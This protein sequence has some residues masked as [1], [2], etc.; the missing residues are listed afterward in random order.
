MGITLD[1]SHWDP[2]RVPWVPS[3]GPLGPYGLVVLGAIGPLGPGAHFLKKK[4]LWLENRAFSLKKVAVAR[5][6]GMG[7][8]HSRATAILF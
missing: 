2:R 7:N 3:V 8:R 1:G 5:E 6:L 4:W